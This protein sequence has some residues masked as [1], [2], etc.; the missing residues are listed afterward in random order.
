MK[1]TLRVARD[2]IWLSCI[3]LCPFNFFDL[4]PNKIFS[5]CIGALLLVSS[6]LQFFIRKIHKAETG[7]KMRWYD[8]IT[9]NGSFK[10]DKKSKKVE[11]ENIENNLF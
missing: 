10:E 4:I 5:I 8:E 1:K 7:K 9:K 2:V 11:Q 3:V 6:I